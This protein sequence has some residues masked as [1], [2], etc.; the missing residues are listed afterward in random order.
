MAASEKL[1]VVVIA[2]R[3]LQDLLVRLLPSGL[4]GQVDFMDYG[5]HRVPGKMTWTLQEAI[6]AIPDPSL[7]V[8]GYGLCGNGLKGIRAGKHT[9]LLPRAD[10][11]IA[12]L[13]GTHQAYT[14]QFE[15]EPGTYYLSKGWLE[16]GSHPHKE[17]LECLAKYGREDAEW[18]LD[19]QY[20]NYSRLV[21]VAHSREDLDKYRPQAL[22]VARF[23]ARWGMRY[24]E[25]L[26]S[27]QYVRR[28]V[29]AAMA[30]QTQRFDL[31]N[32]DFVLIPPG[33]EIQPEMFRR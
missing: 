10:D 4:A 3:V 14:E 30:A 23:C 21:L 16:S 12:I 31:S 5:L 17:Y 6:D 29:E 13:L 1:P 32:Q 22:E 9:L 8:L 7:V 24:E 15:K 20:R 25:V 27:D 18:I 11:C 28:L 33:G 26:G 19:Q 2:C